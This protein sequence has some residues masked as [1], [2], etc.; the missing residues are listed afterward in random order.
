MT[1]PA[2]FYAEDL[3][4]LMK[5]QDIQ[6]GCPDIQGSRRTPASRSSQG[7]G[8]V[9]SLR[10]TPLRHYDLRPLARATNRA[11][12]SKQARFIRHWRRFACFPCAI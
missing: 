2:L 12:A 1:R 10:V 8:C 7:K 9:R 4:F 6:A 3:L 11:A 5:K